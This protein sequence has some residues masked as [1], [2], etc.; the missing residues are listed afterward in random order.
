MRILVIGSGGREHA[1]VWKLAQSNHVTNLYCAPG[2]AGTDLLAENIPIR[3]HDLQNLLDF[4]LKQSIDLTVVGPEVPLVLGIVDLFRAN[5]L[6]IFGP[7]KAA[8]Q[9]EGSKVF[10]KQFMS[11]HHIP[12]AAFH[13]CDSRS[14]M[15]AV[16]RSKEFPYVIKVDGLAAGKGALVIHNQA[17]LDEAFRSIWDEQRFG[18][19]G[20][21]VVV[22]DFLKGEELSVFA[23]TDGSRYIILPSAQDHKRIG[24]NDTG[25][26][27]GGMGAYAP[28]PLGTPEV[29]RQ[30]EE[31]VIIP[32][33]N[34]LRAEGTPYTGVLYC[35]LMIDGIQP[36]VVEFN[37]RFGDPETQVVLPLIESDLSTLLLS[38]ANGNLDTSSV[39]ISRQSAVC[40]VMASAGYPD[41][42]EKGKIIKGLDAVAKQDW[43]IF[44]AGTIHSDSQ[45]KT[46][47]GRVL[48]VTALADDLETAISKAYDHVS[49]INFDGA[50]YRRDI[51]Q[52]GLQ[53]Q[54]MSSGKI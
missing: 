35:G 51:G 5:G 28:A 23:I 9:M 3:D 8:A 16:T 37:A 50:Y 11:R 14:A 27:T 54:K 49:G 36:S 25:P 42:Y 45:F 46:N 22:E 31:Q 2:N 48:A 18:A 19:A 38:A 32:T 34:G 53:R 6:K 1:L 21:K 26:N 47:G 41:A 13:L 4:A 17:D 20:E 33:L 7:T 10:A 24:D 29:L 30:I 39:T 52:K 40:V 44:Q 43:H 15:E 12:T